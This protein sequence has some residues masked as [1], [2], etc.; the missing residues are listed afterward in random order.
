MENNKPPH[1]VENSPTLKSPVTDENGDDNGVK[2]VCPAPPQD[3]KVTEVGSSVK[4]G[5]DE[6]V[7]SA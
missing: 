6:T 7:E 5:E 1:K 3:D 4:E 2:V